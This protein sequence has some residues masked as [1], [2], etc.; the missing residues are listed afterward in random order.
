MGEN[1]LTV[2]DALALQDRGNNNNNDG[3]FGGQGA[4]WVIILILFFAFA[5][6]GNGRNGNGEGGTNTVVIPASM[7]GGYN[8]CC[9]PA[10][11]QGVTDAF[12]FNQLDNG[13]R[14]LERGMCDGFYTTNLAVTN[15]GTQMQ[16][17]FCSSDRAN[18]Q[19]F[20]GVQSAL[21]QGFN[22]INQAIAQTNYNMKD[23]CCET[24]ESIMQSNFNNQSGFNSIQNQ[25]ASC[26]CDLGR[27]QENIKYA[28]AQSTCDIMANADKN[29]DR[30]IN[31]LVQ[32]EMQN[33]RTELQSAQFQLSQNSQTRALIEQLQPCPKPAYIT[34][35]PYQT[36]PN[37]G[38]NFN[39]NCGCC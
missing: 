38:G 15:L 34:C 22:G 6:F 32:N 7:G 36:Y 39:N 3:M 19:S 5:G 25:L 37:Y 14:G 13:I 4:W 33:L 23:C 31:H 16:Q 10:T 24:R 17:G 26:C 27:G 30:I 11:Q 29:T 18:L 2:A 21:C 35:S 20:N 12:N 1:G 28:L 9:T 8:A